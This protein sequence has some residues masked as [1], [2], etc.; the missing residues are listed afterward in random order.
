MVKEE[1]QDEKPTQE[2]V[3]KFHKDIIVQSK[4]KSKNTGTVRISAKTEKELK[5]YIDS[6]V[7]Y[8]ELSHTSNAKNVSPEERAG[9]SYEEPEYEDGIADIVIEILDMNNAGEKT[10]YDCCRLYSYPPDPGGGGD[11]G[12]SDGGSS[13]GGSDGSNTIKTE[14]K[15]PRWWHYGRVRNYSSSV[16]ITYKWFTKYRLHNRWKFKDGGGQVDKRSF[17]ASLSQNRT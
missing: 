4:D 15:G 7:F 14:M 6:R 11:G 10:D 8:L 12:S 5:N 3:Y 13:D 17:T 2:S 16:Y 1:K 9:T